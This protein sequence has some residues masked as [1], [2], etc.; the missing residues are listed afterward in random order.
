MKNCKRAIYIFLTLA[1]LVS[2]VVINGFVSLSAG[3]VW[4]GDVATG[5]SK[6]T[7]SKEDPYII[8]TAEELAYLSQQVRWGYNYADTY[9]ELGADIVLND[10]TDWQK[11]GTYN[12][13][14][15]LIAPINTWTPIGLYGN[16]AFSGYFDGKG[17]TVKGMYVN[18]V[19]GKHFGLFGYAYIYDEYTIKNVNITDS[20]VFGTNNAD[21]YAARVGGVVGYGNAENCSYSGTVTGD[22]GEGNYI[23]VGGIIGWGDAK[24]CTASG[25]VSANDDRSYSAGITGWGNAENCIN[26]SVVSGN[27]VA[28]I[29]ADGDAVYCENYGNL[30]ATYDV[31]GISVYGTASYCKNVGD[32]VSSGGDAAGICANNYVYDLD[33]IVSYCFNSGNITA[34]DGNNVGSIV[35]S[36]IA[37]DCY[38]KGTITATDCSAVGGIAASTGYNSS[39]FTFSRC[40]NA[41]AVSG[42]A[43]YMSAVL[44][45]NENEI[46][47]NNLYYLETAYSYDAYAVSLT[48]SEM[49]LQESFEDFNFNRVWEYLDG[50]E[51]PYPTLRYFGSKIYGYGAEFYDGGKL[52]KSLT[53]SENETLV[54]E[55]MSDKGNLHFYAYEKDGKYYFEGDTLLMTEDVAFNVVWQKVNTGAN[56]WDGTA[57]TDWQGSGTEADPY[58]ITSAEELAGVA[59]KVNGGETYNNKYFSLENDIYLNDANDYG[60]LLVAE[61]LWEPI[62]SYVRYYEDDVYMYT[63]EFDGKFLGNGHTVRGLY[64]KSE[65][66]NI[67]LFGYVNGT[68]TDL[69]IENSYVCSVQNDNYGENRVGAV[70]GYVREVRNCKSGAVVEFALNK[71]GDDSY[72]YIGGVVGYGTTVENCENNGTVRVK[73]YAKDILVG[74][75]YNGYA[76]GVVGSANTVKNCTN[77]GTVCIENVESTGHAYFE[78]SGVVGWAQ[79]VTDCVNN[80][81]VK[82]PRIGINA[83]VSDG[84]TISGVASGAKTV[85]NCKNY[86]TVSG[87]DVAVGVVADA[88]YVIG[89]ENYGKVSGMYAYGIGY[90]LDN[91]TECK[92]SGEI[93]GILVTKHSSPAA[94]G[95]SYRIKSASDC[96]NTGKITLNAITDDYMLEAEASGLFIY[97]EG[98]YYE[99]ETFVI[100]RCKNT[101]SVTL[102]INK[103]NNATYV[104]AAGIICR[105]SGY[106]LVNEC[107]NGGNIYVSNAEFSYS[108]Y[109]VY[110]GGVAGNATVKNSYNTG[111]VA[112]GSISVD[113]DA[114]AAVG[115]IVGEGSAENCYN[116]GNIKIEIDN[117]YKEKTVGGVVGCLNGNVT[118]SYYLD[119]CCTGVL[120]LNAYGEAKTSAELKSKS[121]FNEWD[122]NRYWEFGGVSGYSY[123]NLRFVGSGT[124]RYNVSFV[125]GTSTI[126]KEAFYGGSEITFTAPA[127]RSGYEFAYWQNG[128]V[129]YKTGDVLV[130]ASDLEFVAV[131]VKTNSVNAWDG[132]ADTDWQGSGSEDDPYLISTAEELAGLAEVLKENRDSEYASCFYKQTA[133][134]YINDAFDYSN[135]VMAENMWTPIGTDNYRGS[136][137]KGTYDGGGFT[138]YGLYMKG[139]SQKIGLFGNVENA[140]FKNVNLKNGYVG[141]VPTNPNYTAYIGALV[142]YGKNITVTDCTNYVTVDSLD[143]ADYAGGLVGYT[144]GITAENCVNYGNISGGVAGGI[145]GYVSSSS[146]ETLISFTNCKNCGEIINTD[147]SNNAQTGGIAGRI[148]NSYGYANATFNGC[149]NEGYVYA[150]M[151]NCTAGIVGIADR[152][153]ISYCENRADIGGTAGIIGYS[154]NYSSIEYCKNYGDVVSN[155]NFAAGIA[156]T[157]HYISNCENYGN[158]TAKNDAGGIAVYYESAYIELCTNKGNVTSINKLAAGIIVNNYYGS[159]YDSTNF[160]KITARNTAGGIAALGLSAVN[161]INNGEIVSEGDGINHAG[162]IIGETGSSYYGN[163]RNCSNTAPVSGGYYVG[164]I[165]GDLD[166]SNHTVTDCVNT[167]DITGEY[168]VGGIVGESDGTVKCSYNAGKITGGHYVGGIVGDGDAELSYNAGRV[169]G[170]YDTGGIC[171]Y[172][173]ATDCYNKAYVT[174]GAYTGG[175]VGNGDAVRCY[176]IGSVYSEEYSP[177]SITCGGNATDCYYLN[178]I[179]VA[180]DSEYYLPT[181]NGTQVSSTELASGT[182]SG[183]DWETV[184]T[185]G[186]VEEY[187]FPTL[188]NTAHYVTYTVTFLDSDG[189]TVLK[190]QRVNKG[191]SAYPPTVETTTDE[192]YVYALDH[193][194]G[195]YGNITADTT[196]KAVYRKT[197]KIKFVGLHH[198]ITV[199]FGFSADNLRVI[200]ESAYSR[201]LC[202]TTHDYKMNCRVIWDLSN[203]NPD[204]SGMYELTGTLTITESPYYE[205]ATGERIIVTVTVL[206]GAENEFDQSHLT[207]SVNDDNTVTIIGYTGSAED[208]RIPETLGGYKVSAIA[209]NAFNGNTD[210]I[211]VYIPKTVQTIGARAFEGCSALVQ[212]TF[213][214]GLETVGEYAF[215]DTALTNV[216]LP[217][218]LNDIGERAFG[219]YNEEYFPQGFTVYAFEGTAACTYAEENGIDLVTVESKTDSYTGITVIAE[220]GVELS[221]SKVFGGEYFDTANTIAEK[222][223]VS[224]FEIKIFDSTS[225]ELQPGNMMTVS[226]PVPAGFADNCKIYRINSDGSYMDMNAQVVDGMLV[227][228]TAHLSY[229]AI[230]SENDVILGD[231]DGNGLVDTTDLAL[232]KLHL[233]GIDGNVSA[234]ADMNADG[235]VDTT[236]LAELKLRL[237]GV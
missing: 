156:G 10:T 104:S 173:D 135:T 221:V 86:G 175:V 178:S 191:F 184:W 46:E 179:S 193:W 227:F 42:S 61:N 137:F 76:S 36:G 48:D 231:A 15:Q 187:D 58:K 59:E 170:D 80:G 209:D 19:T 82:M 153:K 157:A 211:S 169:I 63:P 110:I 31:A 89:C 65:S 92:N 145:V 201:L 73:C 14:N 126:S 197:E 101:G 23:Y 107:Y 68:I 9:F 163:I 7:G 93:N 77:N 147:Y 125:D 203:Y 174:G 202:T 206:E 148:S 44:A 64:V 171:G 166:Y 124:H 17:Y 226:I 35:A 52:V 176:N 144:D 37:Q 62:G 1:I 105:T 212:V 11:W 129:Q 183:F 26:Y 142:S 69:N 164:G 181:F 94:S 118:N 235:N 79:S 146:T 229:Y 72:E 32:I 98:A 127:K 21:Y 20:F 167:G 12:D 22:D 140:T 16:Y 165:V 168:T 121:S 225:D 161:C 151:G 182:L 113:N 57:D 199:P 67:G 33:D 213:C 117:S 81:T 18:N 120:S 28:G 172:G 51:Y 130:V 233:A 55:K 109:Y 134:I 54:F 177:A 95:I 90:N 131:W 218:S 47:T 154:N 214:E 27:M 186:E 84:V 143:Y 97:S 2:A 223:N 60:Y 112:V 3:N 128:T 111:S 232:L 198:S 136:V 141:Y 115:G 230:V 237:A 215:G 83:D 207:Y 4:S 133:D 78:L 155:Y 50:A 205:M 208:I 219:C 74:L 8:T 102:N 192:N 53:I 116:V 196:V 119:S 91:V 216:T 88:D 222:A 228:N 159:V 139:N 189:K 180:T 39:S 99:E 210:I 195:D 87:S 204:A 30:T 75:P 220:E 70:A 185:V 6:G 149:I 234:G 162:G 100:E 188:R 24:N 150:K 190:E 25:S 29:T 34:T 43:E 200:V 160:G 96:E 41:G 138:V 114:E 123:P 49:K 40:Y 236:D 224:L 158:I 45:T 217:A 106:A 152:A 66:G 56:V 103:D 13:E 108:G 85:T 132:T 5:F 71:N 194:D 38:N 122:F